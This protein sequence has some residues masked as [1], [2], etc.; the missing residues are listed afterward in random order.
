MRSVVVTGPRSLGVE[1]IPDPTPGPGQLVLR[2]GA[3]GICGSDLHAHQLGILP[4]GSVMGHEFSG[5]VMESAHGWKAGERACALPALSCGSCE[6]CLS[7]LGVFCTHGM[8]GI[9][10]GQA[11][12]AYAEYVAVSTHHMVRLPA[13]VDQRHGALVEPLAVGLH[14]VNVAALRAAENVLV[15]GAGPI[16]LAALVWARHFGARSVIV[17]EKSPGRRAM[18]AALGASAV[19]DPADGSLLGALQP[20]AP[21]GVDVVFEAVGLPGLIASA[22]QSVKF[23]GR[24]VVVGVCMQQDS[25]MPFAGIAK[26]AS[27]HFVLAYEKRDFEYTVDML[28]QGRIAPAA[29]ITDVVGLDGVAAAFDALE[30]PTTQSKVMVVP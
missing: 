19:V 4:R 14:A 30:H 5:E 21:G 13:G 10:L 26:E 27:L 7:G 23:R 3:C 2:V 18:A 17:S 1:T 16:G 9:G 25:F 22:L 8:K 6:R 29:M 20:L 24:V 12:G 11:P 15:L 28:E